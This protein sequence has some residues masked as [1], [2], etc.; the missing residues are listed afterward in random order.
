MEV[1]MTT[2]RQGPPSLLSVHFLIGISGSIFEAG[3]DPPNLL[4]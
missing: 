3:I 2:D 4:D 1:S